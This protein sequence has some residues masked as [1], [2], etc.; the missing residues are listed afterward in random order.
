MSL[1]SPSS[2]LSGVL[3]AAQFGCVTEA[4]VPPAC[5]PH[6]VTEVTQHMQTA[7]GMIR[8]RIMNSQA[9]PFTDT[10]KLVPPAG[11]YFLGSVSGVRFD[12]TFAECHE[13]E[14]GIICQTGDIAGEH[15]GAI[16]NY[17]Q[18]ALTQS[19]TYLETPTSNHFETLGLDNAKICS[20]TNGLTW[21]NLGCESAQDVCKQSIADLSDEIHLTLGQ[22][23]NRTNP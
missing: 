11:N 20:A 18:I 1:R 7:L 3:L 9:Q 5:E 19:G 10:L 14:A 22:F 2:A 6:M 15:P 4:A 16:S 23:L 21:G 8:G 17:T 13:N 12:N